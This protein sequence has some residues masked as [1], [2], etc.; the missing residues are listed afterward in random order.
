MNFKEPT[1]LWQ[2]RDCSISNWIAGLGVRPW[3][4]KGPGIWLEI[5]FRVSDR[6][7]FRKISFLPY[8][9][10]NI[11][12]DNAVDIYQGR[13]SCQEKC[14]GFVGPSSRNNRLPKAWTAIIFAVMLLYF[15]IPIRCLT[16]PVS[17]VIVIVRGCMCTENYEGQRSKRVW[18][19]L[20][21]LSPG[22]ADENQ[23]KRVWRG[24]AVDENQSWYPSIQIP[25]WAL[26]W[27]PAR[28]HSYLWVFHALCGPCKGRLHNFP[29]PLSL[30]AKARYPL[31]FPSK[32]EA[33]HTDS[34]TLHTST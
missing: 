4:S 2:R 21:W 28:E 14:C 11:E 22:V 19:V 3:T 12:Q 10:G 27:V 29:S 1:Y 8:D 17:T 20:C 18:P 15:H 23:R 30:L 26:G 34:P 25:P 5:R 32:H 6:F 31:P 7:L 13:E 33:I 16:T 24:G 9:N